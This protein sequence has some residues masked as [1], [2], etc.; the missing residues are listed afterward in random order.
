M[1][2]RD[3]YPIWYQKNRPFAKQAGSI[4]SGSGLVPATIESIQLKIFTK[5]NESLSRGTVSPDEIK[6]D[7]IKE[8]GLA[9]YYGSFCKSGRQI[10]AVSDELGQMFLH[11]SAKDVPISS[12]KSPYDGYFIQFHSPV[13]WGQNE[14]VG[15]FIMDEESI[16]MLQVCLVLN[17]SDR[18]EHWMRSPAG[19]FL[20]TLDR[21]NGDAT[22]AKLIEDS[23][24][25][26]IVAKWETASKA[27]NLPSNLSESEIIDRRSERAM[28]E[29]MDLKSAK[30]AIN[31]ALSYVANC[32]CYLSSDELNRSVDYTT[33]T[34][35]SLLEKLQSSKTPKAVQ[36]AKSLLSNNGYIPI[37]YIGKNVGKSEISLGLSGSVVKEHWRRG[38]W[39]NQFYGEARSER[40]LIWIKPTLVGHHANEQSENTARV[41]KVHNK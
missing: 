9:A 37:T 36:K 26:E 10:F 14:I 35:K 20:I 4:I 1:M 13:N 31:I 5:W 34:P 18:G 17:P 2:S 29:S 40:K 15:A 7:L 38:H 3:I 22:L 16:P 28:R 11:T 30:E 25:S 23:I 39:R 41:Y 12:L 27:M 24:E 6:T 33:D 19:Y 21:D 32:L 8:I